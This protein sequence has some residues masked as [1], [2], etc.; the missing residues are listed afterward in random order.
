M[1]HDLQRF[2]TIC[3]NAVNAIELTLEQLASG[4]LNAGDLLAQILESGGKILICGNGGSAAEAMHMSAELVGRFEM[5]R[6][7]LAAVALGSDCPILTALSNDFDYEKVFAKQIQALGSEQD[8]L[9]AITTSGN[10]GNICRAIEAAHD[11]EIP[12]V[13]ISGKDGGRAAQLLTSNDIE[14]RVPATSTARIQEVHLLLVHSLCDHI[15]HS[16]FS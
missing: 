2:R 3:N 12:V 13:L 7:G 1:P 10:S 15:D 4:V 9:I 6:P 11:T 16:L 14:L 5:D 8:V